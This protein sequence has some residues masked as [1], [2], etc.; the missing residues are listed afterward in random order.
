MKYEVKEQFTVSF[1]GATNT[2]F[3]VGDE[4][5]DRSCPEALTESLLKKDCLSP[6]KEEKVS[7]KALKVKENKAMKSKENK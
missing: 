7:K 6:L 3:K 2:S 4:F 1:D 5:D